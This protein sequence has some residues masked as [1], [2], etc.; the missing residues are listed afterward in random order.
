[1]KIAAIALLL[2]LGACSSTHKL[3]E[4]RGS[5]AA[6]NPGKWLPAPEDLRK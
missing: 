4:C 1:M 6:A 5:F 3:T 2:A